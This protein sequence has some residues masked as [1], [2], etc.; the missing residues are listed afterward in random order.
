LVCAAI[1]LSIT[2]IT[3]GDTSKVPSDQTFE[4]EGRKCVPASVCNMEEK[5]KDE[6]WYFEEMGAT[7]KTVAACD[8]LDDPT[9]YE[10]IGRLEAEKSG[11][12]VKRRLFDP[13]QKVLDGSSSTATRRF[14][15]G[16]VQAIWP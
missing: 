11:H 5:A 2:D 16:A 3:D 10:P 15:Y 13:P 14:N 7:L 9:D 1:T 6:G 4:L 12:I 8:G